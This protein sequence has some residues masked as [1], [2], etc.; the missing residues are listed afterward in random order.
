[1]MPPD[2]DRRY[3]AV[4]EALA[5]VPGVSYDPPDTGRRSFGEGALKVEGKIFAMMSQGRFVV[6]LPRQRVEA[7]VG[8][9]DGARFDPGH[10]RP[11]CEWLSLEP[12]SS[13]DWLDL[14]REALDFVTPKR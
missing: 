3:A 13:L 11:M 10:G 5:G 14:A 1:M 4:I 6:K 8:S 12:D 9:G 7:L 2:I